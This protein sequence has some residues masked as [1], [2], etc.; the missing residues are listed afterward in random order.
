LR[1]T[2]ATD[3]SSARDGEVT[4]VLAPEL[5]SVVV[6]ERLDK[7]AEVVRDAAATFAGVM[8]TRVEVVPRG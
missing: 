2:V 5:W 1:L 8:L 6:A 3:R 7:V 4:L